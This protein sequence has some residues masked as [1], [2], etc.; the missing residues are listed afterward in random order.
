MAAAWNHNIHYHDLLLSA[1][2]TPCPEALDVGSG[3]GM[4][5][6]RLAARA[7]AVTAIDLSKQMVDAA[8]QTTMG[9][10]NVRFI[11]G[12][13]L[14]ATMPAREFDYIS[15]LAAIHHMDF[16]PAIEKMRRLLRNGG[17]LVILG[18]A[19]DRSLRDFAASAAAIP[20]NRVLRLRRGW[21]EPA[22][23]AERPGM[24]YGQV[25]AAARSLLPGVELRRLLFFR[26]L[27][28]WRKPACS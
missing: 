10:P 5:A 23:P 28:L 26:Y 12:D 17:V 27:L 4:F 1:V 16:V 15:C 21:Y 22:F 19:R 8:K 11:H 9:F 6:L 24:S 14:T 18:L 3:D 2:P 7:D 13:F 20:V 25:F